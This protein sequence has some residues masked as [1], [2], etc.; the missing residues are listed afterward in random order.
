V[1]VLSSPALDAPVP[2]HLFSEPTLAVRPWVDDLIDT[3][4]HDPRSTYVERTGTPA[5]SE[6]G[7]CLRAAPSDAGRGGPAGTASEGASAGGFPDRF[8]VRPWVDHVVESHGFPA[9]SAYTETVL[10]PI[11]GPSATFALRR[12]GT[13]AAAQAEGLVVDA[14]E[15]ARDLGLGHKGGRN[16]TMARTIGRLCQF[17]MAEWRGDVLMV[18]TAVAPVSERQLVRLSPRVVQAHR[19]MVHLLQRRDP[20]RLPSVAAG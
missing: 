14:S 18:R 13:W 20:S 4:G 8:V 5:I 17:G 9:N 1:T 3:L 15:L 7:E 12:L 19:S 6:G 16:S 2:I 11:L 10:L